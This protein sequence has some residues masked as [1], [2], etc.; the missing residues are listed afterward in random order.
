MYRFAV[1][2]V[3]ASEMVSLFDILAG[4]AGEIHRRYII[5]IIIIIIMFLSIINIHIIITIMISCSLSLL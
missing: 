1:L 5:I 4:E 2:E 3:E